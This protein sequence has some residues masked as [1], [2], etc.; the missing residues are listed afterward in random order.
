MNL[1]FFSDDKVNYE[2]NETV[3]IIFKCHF[4][5]NIIN[6]LRYTIVNNQITCATFTK[7]LAVY[8]ASILIFKNMTSI[9]NTKLTTLTLVIKIIKIKKYFFK[10]KICP[11]K[12]K[13]NPTGIYKLTSNYVANY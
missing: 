5:Y 3:Y 6:P 9:L 1:I 11:L 4:L 10:A 8:L 12:V 7:L 13:K 2:Y